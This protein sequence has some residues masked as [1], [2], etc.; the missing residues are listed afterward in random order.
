MSLSANSFQNI[1]FDRNTFIGFDQTEINK[2]STEDLLSLRKAVYGYLKSTKLKKR[3]GNFMEVFYRINNELKKRNKKDNG[4]DDLSYKPC[5]LGQKL[6]RD[7]DDDYYSNEYEKLNYFEDSD[8]CSRKTSTQS[9][10]TS[11]FL[12]LNVP[13]FLNDKTIKIQKSKKNLHTKIIPSCEDNDQQNDF[14]SP[15]ILLNDIK[16][17]FTHKRKFLFF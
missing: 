2:T 16:N 3:N 9:N 6:L 13:S 8:I 12:I 15:Q 5:Y 14:Y 1:K 17:V 4:T 11:N 7:L 10:Q